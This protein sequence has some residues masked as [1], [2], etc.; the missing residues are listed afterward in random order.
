VLTVNWAVV[1][2]AS[3][4][5]VLEGTVATAVLLLAMF[6]TI[7][8]VGARPLRVTVAV[9]VAPPTTAVGLSAIELNAG[10]FTV[11]P[12]VLELDR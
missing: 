1:D 5:I 8:P 4:V 3:T 2:P 9:E 12:A 6:T 7:P 10:G 11:R